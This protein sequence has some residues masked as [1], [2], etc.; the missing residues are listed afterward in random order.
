TGDTRNVTTRLGIDLQN[1]LQ[2]HQY[3]EHANDR[4]QDR[5]A[6]HGGGPGADQS[7]D[8]DTPRH[9]TEQVP[10][11]STMLMMGSNRADGRKYNSCQRRTYGQVGRNFGADTHIPKTENQHRYDDQA[12]TD[13]E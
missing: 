13:A 6:Q 7:A 3:C 12:T 1:H 8:H 2:S 10:T 5:P 9:G 4:L 11:H